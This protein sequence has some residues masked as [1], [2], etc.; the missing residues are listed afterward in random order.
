MR[1][2]SLPGFAHALQT[3]ELTKL[4]QTEGVNLLELPP[5]KNLGQK[6]C[7]PIFDDFATKRQV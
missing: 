2:S 1:F 4:C 6:N 3:T 5:R 7:G